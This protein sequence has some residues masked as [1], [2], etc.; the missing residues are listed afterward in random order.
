[1]TSVNF[2]HAFDRWYKAT[3]AEKKRLDAEKNEGRAILSWEALDHLCGLAVESGMKALML[4]EKM[5]TG[6]ASGDFPQGSDGRRPHVNKLWDLF[7]TK[8]TGH[9]RA[10]WAQRLGTV[11]VFQTWRTENRYAPDGTVQE[12]ELEA[13]MKVAKKLKQIAQEEGL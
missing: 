6:D 2:D 13:R 4:K 8:A 10:E 3:E 7:M 1:M 5:V 9:K 12:S 11:K